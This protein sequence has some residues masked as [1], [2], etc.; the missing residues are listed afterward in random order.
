MH[1]THLQL[2]VVW[3]VAKDHPDSKK[4]NLLQTHGLLFLISCKVLFYSTHHSL[5]YTSCGALTGIKDCTMSRPSII[6]LPLAPQFNLDKKP[7]YITCKNIFQILLS[8]KFDFFSLSE[9][10]WSN[11]GAPSINSITIYN[12]SSENNKSIPLVNSNRMYTFFLTKIIW[13][14]DSDTEVPELFQ[15]L[16][17]IRQ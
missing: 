2:Y 11:N 14:S 3:H 1:S 8:S 17:A 13:T 4:G 7:R 9:L 5:C 12:L 6:E 16:L 15:T 10:K